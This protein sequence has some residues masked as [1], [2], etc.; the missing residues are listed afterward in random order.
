MNSKIFLM[1]TVAFVWLSEAAWSFEAFPFIR[2]VGASRY[3]LVLDREARG[4]P[5]TTIIE[6]LQLPTISPR[7]LVIS[8]Q[9]G[10]V[11][12]ERTLGFAGINI[13]LQ[14]V[15]DMA[16]YDA[17][18]FYIQSRYAKEKFSFVLY[19][20]D[21]A[22]GEITYQ[23]DFDLNCNDF[24]RSVSQSRF[25]VNILPPDMYTPE[26]SF[27]KLGCSNYYRLPL[28]GFEKTRRGRV[29]ETASFPARIS[30]IGI[31]L[32]RSKQPSVGEGVEIPFMYKLSNFGATAAF[33]VREEKD[34]P[35]RF[36]EL[37]VAR[38]LRKSSDDFSEIPRP[39]F[40]REE[41]VK[42][43]FSSPYIVNSLP[44]G[45]RFAGT[46][47]PDYEI[48]KMLN[49][50]A[51][52]YS[53]RQIYD[54]WLTKVHD[55]VT[56][57]Y[58]LPSSNSFALRSLSPLQLEN[59]LRARIERLGLVVSDKLIKY[60]IE[61]VIFPN[62]R[63][64][65]LSQ[66]LVLSLNQGVVFDK[67]VF[68]SSIGTYS[69]ALSV[70]FLADVTESVAPRQFSRFFQKITYAVDFVGLPETK[71]RLWQLL[72]GGSDEQLAFSPSFWNSVLN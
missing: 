59:F 19:D 11:N 16:G 48:V 43:Y 36:D 41:E 45:S 71:W 69:F 55:D 66:E 56:R 68:G 2:D 72:F 38:R 1:C 64:T 32:I 12:A 29:L 42:N 63:R 58:T 54:A 27:Q 67:S 6:R 15:Q 14:R 24:F 44:I 35:F 28:E 57:F 17:I 26:N 39:K 47:Y 13:P 62:L 23:F 30:K 37:D 8:G 53:S 61:S 4:I 34:L 3:E 65:G 52:I 60:E 33:L 70:L 40:L 10:W 5:S 49:A 51:K 46:T 21:D 18:Y 22:S 31:R 7:E 9:V 25:G 20:A 50:I